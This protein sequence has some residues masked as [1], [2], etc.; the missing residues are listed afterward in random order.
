MDFY[1]Q[2]QPDYTL[3]AD[4]IKVFVDTG[5]FDRYLS[6]PDTA[7][8]FFS[9]CL[10][11]FLDN[12]NV[13]VNNRQKFLDIRHEAINGNFSNK[14]KIY[15]LAYLCNFSSE[16]CLYQDKEVKDQF[17]EDYTDALEY[18]KDCLNPNNLEENQVSPNLSLEE[19]NLITV[20]L[21]NLNNPYN[22]AEFN[23]SSINVN[24]FIKA[25]NYNEIHYE[26]NWCNYTNV[27]NK[28][29]KNSPAYI[30]TLNHFNELINNP[31]P[32]EQ[33]LTENEI[34]SYRYK[35]DTIMKFLYI[36]YIRSNPNFPDDYNFNLDEYNFITISINF[37]NL[38]IL[39]DNL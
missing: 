21:S 32:E 22:S 6:N 7:I 36:N 10:N 24:L 11:R 3:L 31:N 26:I 29:F 38:H 14:D 16:M 8:E 9:Y 4:R 13:N 15:T 23:I 33:Q 20:E 35:Y 19:I 1:N 25:I 18:L 30:N 27:F 17:I 28:V 34:M 5:S 12:I 2:N 39:Q 37:L